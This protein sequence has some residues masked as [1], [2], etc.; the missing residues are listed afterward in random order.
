M[1]L[2]EIDGSDLLEK[3]RNE[4]NF[5]LDKFNLEGV[6]IFRAS[7]TYT[8]DGL[9]LI[10]PNS[11]TND[12]TSTA[13]YN[14]VTTWMSNNPQWADYPKRG[15]SL[16]CSTNLD[17]ANFY[18]TANVIVPLIDCKI[19][20]CPI[21]D[22]WYSF[23]TISVNRITNN[24]NKCFKQQWPNDN[25]KELTYQELLKKLK[26]VTSAINYRFVDDE[27]EQVLEKF[28][29]AEA[30]MLSLLDPVK[31]KFSLTTW[32]QYNMVTNKYNAKELWLSAP[33]VRI[34]TITFA[35]L[36]MERLNATS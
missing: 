2:F 32:K 35:K 16:I 8:Q 18:G 33:C 31:N 11:R 4:I 20:I 28:T 17:S 23:D 1:R 21:N 12:R 7:L 6:A 5:A 9:M 14:Y 13:D 3:Y 15:R 36:A 24:L 29:N 10:D 30:M 26:E 19:G 22:I 34:D 25:N 27:F